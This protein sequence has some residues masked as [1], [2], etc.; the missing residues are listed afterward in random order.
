[1]QAASRVRVWSWEPARREPALQE[2][3][4]GAPGFRTPGFR[5]PT[6]GLGQRTR[7]RRRAKR[8]S[9]DAD[10]DA[11]GSE[12]TI[13]W[14]PGGEASRAG[15]KNGEHTAASEAPADRTGDRFM[16]EWS[17]VVLVSGEALYHLEGRCQ[18]RPTAGPTNAARKLR[19]KRNLA[20][21]P[22]DRRDGCAPSYL[23]RSLS[24]GVSP[25]ALA[26]VRPRALLRAP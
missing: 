11:P 17:R 22:A 18:L 19:L 16:V 1:M 4:S 9:A 2:V 25:F 24:A 7:G 21:L 14:V 3:R 8:L 5:V 12:K 10:T 13:S 26:P 6:F 15:G 23:C 20:G